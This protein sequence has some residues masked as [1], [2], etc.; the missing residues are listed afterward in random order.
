[1]KRF[2]IYLMTFIFILSG[3]TLS[4]TAE[5]SSE[6]IRESIPVNPDSNSLRGVWIS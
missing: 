5:N 2:F 4:D 1:M 3:C 6:V